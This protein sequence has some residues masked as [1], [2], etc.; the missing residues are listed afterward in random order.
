MSDNSSVWISPV[1]KQIDNMTDYG[2][3]FH[4]Y[5]Q[6][7]LYS[8]N[9][10]FGTAA[11]LSALSAALHQ[12]GMALMVDVVVNHFGSPYIVDYSSYVP[13]NDGSYFH[14]EAFITDYNNQ[15]MVEQGWLGNGQVPLPDI[16]T[17]NPVVVSTFN[18]WISK[19]VQ[20][21]QIDGL[22]LDTVKHVRQDFWPGFISAG[23]VFALGEVL[24]GD[25]NY[26]ASYQ[27]YVGGLLDYGTYY[28]L[29][30]SFS[31]GGDM[32]ELMALLAPSYRSKFTDTQLLATFMENHDMPRFT[33]GTSA[34]LTVIRNAMAYTL[35][36]D[37]IPIIYYGQE[38]SFTGAGDPTNR[39][40]L[41][42]SGFKITPLYNY[43][44]YLNQ[45]RKLAWTAG[46]GTN[47]T[48][49]LY[50]D[51]SSTVTQKGPLLLVLSNAGS[52]ASN[53][54]ISFPT[55][56]A[57][58]T[59]LVNVLTCN[60]ILVGKS[61]TSVT[62]SAGAAQ[63]YLPQGL[64]KQ[65]C[66]NISAPAASSTSVLS[67]IASV[68]TS[69]SKTAAR[70]AAK[71]SQATYSSG[72]AATT[73]QGLAIT[74]SSPTSSMPSLTSSSGGGGG[75]GGRPVFQTVSASS[76]SATGRP[77]FVTSPTS[78][79][80]QSSS[81]SSSRAA[82]MSS[83][84]KSSSTSSPRATTTAAAAQKISSTPSS[85]QA[86]MTT[87]S[88][89]TTRKSSSTSGTTTN[90]RPVFVTS[91]VSPTQTTLQKRSGP[92][93]STTLARA[94]ASP[95]SPQIQQHP[96]QTVQTHRKQ[97]ARTNPPASLSQHYRADRAGH[98]SPNAGHGLSTTYSYS[99]SHLPLPQNLSERQRS[100]SETNLASSLQNGNYRKG[101]TAQS[102]S[103]HTLKKR[104]SSQSLAVVQSASRAN[105]F[106]SGIPPV[107]AIVP[108]LDTRAALFADNAPYATETRSLS[109]TSLAMPPASRSRRSSNASVYSTHAGGS[110]AR[111]RHASLERQN[112]LAQENGVPLP[113]ANPGFTDHGSV[114][115]R[116]N[117][118]MSSPSHGHSKTSLHSV[119][120]RHQMLALPN[121][122]RPDH[123]AQL[124]QD[125]RQF[126]V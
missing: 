47:L 71:S 55:Q 58:G 40:A 6:Q 4:G 54:T 82:T 96:A 72:T 25:P 19:L 18:Q 39:Q 33:T 102:Q 7:D 67:K 110:V 64:A 121:Q 48:T 65:M 104:G 90:G 78:S 35:L 85:A 27:P 93:A 92:K 13:F 113:L 108:R 56:F 68:F 57:S 28:P 46:F 9:P 42:T 91:A 109:S 16:D 53:K 24:S 38:Q 62:I 125:V 95:V 70:S 26:L 3:A 20:T 30:R 1:T 99:A 120:D 69:S 37:G 12:R 11:D 86:F 21:Y 77:Q 51:G 36:S 112:L 89:S 75:G 32:N 123:R 119:V 61:T 66:T 34:D 73:T 103:L 52:G 43:L 117:D 101:H 8:L 116:A 50:V 5:W 22:R 44:A 41:W 80:P 107:P 79:V 2:E 10:H 97:S 122:R 23:G 31:S 114:Q 63:V 98:S 94:P 88:M 83:I 106:G 60:S 45:A 81:T 49:G 15:T 59:I 100:S 111:K 105:S 87:S 76:A 115:H 14:E 17:E 126:R 118:I 124:Q 29:L 74:K 84:Q